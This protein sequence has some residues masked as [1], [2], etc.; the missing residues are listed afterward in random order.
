MNLL[1]I[2]F[3]TQDDNA[4]T[5]NI[6]EVGAAWVSPGREPS[7]LSIFCYEPSYP[8][9]T[10]FIEDLTGISDEILKRDGISRMDALTRLM[11]LIEQ[12]DV[13]FAHK[14]AFDQTVFEYTCK[15]LGLT[16]PQ[17]EWICTLTEVEWPKKMTCLKLGHLAFEF[18]L[19]DW[20]EGKDGKYPPGFDRNMLHR[21]GDDSE[22]L[23]YL[24]THKLGLDNV[25]KYAREKWVYFKAD[26]LP[27]WKDGGEQNAIVKKL[28]FSY[29]KCKHTEFPVWPKSWVIRVKERNADSIKKLEV[30]FRISQI[31]GV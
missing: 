10:P 9:Q 14:K 31:E 15:R 30:P 20:T 1:A 13:I 3:E 21:A 17:K 26:V 4:K 19:F 25:L 23:L 16:F 8:P 29:E 28:G 24:V 6:T 11:P 12:A 7:K 2:D 5:T 27:P 18:G 22:L